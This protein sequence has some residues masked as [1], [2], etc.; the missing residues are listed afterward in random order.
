M[1]LENEQKNIAYLRVS[2]KGENL[3][4]QEQ[5]IKK[6][7]NEDLKFYRDIEHGDIKARNRPGYNQLV[8]D[9]KGSPVEARPKKLYVY[10]ISRI[11][12]DHLETL[13]NIITLEKTYKIQVLSVSSNESWINTSSTEIRGLILSIM[14]WQ[15]EQE[16]KAL[17]IRTKEALTVKKETLARDGY[18]ISRKGKKITKLGRPP[19]LI[20]WDQYSDLR[21][22]G[23][24]ISSICRMLGYHYPWFI[25]KKK[26]HDESL[27]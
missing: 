8:E 23:Y 9:I 24:S 3:E 13:T 21:N 18:F 14:T 1:V 12:R 11:G 10:E 7:A 2:I 20:D 4:N 27:K 15:Y 19:R 22:K 17:R 5:A 25:I 26:E 16:L 6:F